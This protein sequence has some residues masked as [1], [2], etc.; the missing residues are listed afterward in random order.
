MAVDPD[1]LPWPQLYRS[2]N[3]KTTCPAEFDQ[4]KAE[5]EAD[6]PKYATV[7]SDS[8]LLHRAAEMAEAFALRAYDSVHLAAAEYL[9]SGMNETVTFLC[10]DRRLC[11]AASVLR[12]HLIN[13]S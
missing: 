10:F 8:G 12:M 13:D 11:Q 3:S 6:W 7:A 4:V 2:A 1:L 9:A 5:F